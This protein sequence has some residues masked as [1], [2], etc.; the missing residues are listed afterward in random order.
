MSK[1]NR[2]SQ[3]IEAIFLKSYQEGKTD[4]PFTREEIIALF[5]FEMAEEGIA[6]TS[7]KHYRLVPPD[8][9]TVEELEK[10]KTRIG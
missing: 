1:L 4:I 3:I 10:Y 9:V 5:E 2:Y 6:V 7:E 8:D